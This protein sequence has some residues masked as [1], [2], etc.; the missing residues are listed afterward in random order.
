M[1]HLSL[2]PQI[3]VSTPLALKHRN[4]PFRVQGFLIHAMG[5]FIDLDNGPVHATAF[6][7][8]RGL[9]AHF[10]IKPDGSI[11]QQV[12]CDFGAN[13]AGKST[14][15]G[16]NG[17]NNSFLGVELLVEG[18]HTL[19]SLKQA[20]KRNPYSLTQID[21]LAALIASAKKKYGFNDDM[22]TGHSIV[23]P[24]RKFDPGPQ[25]ITANN[26]YSDQF[27]HA[28]GKWDNFFDSE[29]MSK[30]A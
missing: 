24:G 23:S 22:V 15:N 2:P 4:Q 14:F 8:S 25:I 16:L 20:M 6:L 3:N 30:A 19:G 28:M 5:E 1:T 17:L 11:E 18:A 12:D 9:S 21:A 10:F 7:K 26:A 13:H 29:T 27:Q